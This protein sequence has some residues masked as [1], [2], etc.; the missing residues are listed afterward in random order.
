MTNTDDIYANTDI[1]AIGQY[2]AIK[3][4]IK[5]IS[6]GLLNISP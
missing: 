5:C 2:H 1:P 6:Q 4:A 3:L